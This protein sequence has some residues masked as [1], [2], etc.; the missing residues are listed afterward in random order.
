MKRAV[1]QL[2]IGTTILLIGFF[3]GRLFQRLKDDKDRYYFKLLDKKE[4]QSPL[5]PVEWN[6]VIESVGMPFLDPGTTII[7]FQNR[8]VYKAQRYFQEDCPYARNIQ[9]QDKWINWEDGEY[10]FQLTIEELNKLTNGPKD[11]I[12]AATN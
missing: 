8:T 1:I 4:Y 11:K 12:G 3:G 6:Y 5:G 10:K 7:K 9:I 2:T